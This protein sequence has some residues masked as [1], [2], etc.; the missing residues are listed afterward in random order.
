MINKGKFFF[1]TENCR[2]LSA[3]TAF[4]RQETQGTDILPSKKYRG[5]FS[6][7]LAL[8]WQET[9]GTDILP[10]NKIAWKLF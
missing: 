7:E 4:S 5:I 1:P 6:A 10:L 2:N 9:L 3:E 8:P